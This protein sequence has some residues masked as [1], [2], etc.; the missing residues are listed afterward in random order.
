LPAGRRAYTPALVQRRERSRRGKPP[1]G[2]LPSGR[3]LGANRR[4][5]LIDLN[6]PL[7]SDQVRSDRCGRERTCAPHTKRLVQSRHRTRLRRNVRASSAARLC[8]FL[9]ATRPTQSRAGW[10]Y[11][12]RREQ[13]S[14][15]PSR[16]TRTA[17]RAQ[18]KSRQRD[19]ARYCQL[20]LPPCPFRH[21][22]G[23]SWPWD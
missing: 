18:Q 9:A 20:I 5:R 2:R 17:E 21:T 12:E 14:A 22:H 4:K 8:C 19:M 10:G 13:T 1:E 6:Q 16:P 11:S 3:G 23:S 15:H 7:Y